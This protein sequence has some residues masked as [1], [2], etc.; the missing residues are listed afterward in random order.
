[1][2]ELP[3]KRNEHGQTIF[4]S[5]NVMACC[6]HL[7][8]RLFK[9]LF[10]CSPFSL[11]HLILHFLTKCMFS[12]IRAHHRW[13]GYR[14]TRT[15]DLITNKKKMTWMTYPVYRSWRHLL[16]LCGGHIFTFPMEFHIW[17][18]SAFLPASWTAKQFYFGRPW[19]QQ[20]QK[21]KNNYD[22]VPFSSGA[23]QS[24]R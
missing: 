10:H 7:P 23:A 12:F 3:W 11:S 24:F 4:L 18:F 14:E 6:S 21:K 19:Q 1:M 15:V 9:C 5:D 20:Q 8:W 17:F 2:R 22:P 16:G 13:T